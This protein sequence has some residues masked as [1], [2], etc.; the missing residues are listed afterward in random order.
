[1]WWKI[2]ALDAEKVVLAIVAREPRSG[3]ASV[4]CKA[5]LAVILEVLI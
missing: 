3:V 4:Q 1:M 2:T 5:S